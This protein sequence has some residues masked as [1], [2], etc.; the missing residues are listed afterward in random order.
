MQQISPNITKLTGHGMLAKYPNQPAS[1]IIGQSFLKIVG[2][3]AS[4]ME[5]VSH[6]MF[7]LNTPQEGAPANIFKDMIQCM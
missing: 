2:H 5:H 4:T 6:P 3:A 1:N 7:G